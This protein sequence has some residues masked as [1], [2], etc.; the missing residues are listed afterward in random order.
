MCGIPRIYPNAVTVPATESF[1]GSFVKLNVAQFPGEDVE[2][3]HDHWRPVAIFQA[4]PHIVHSS[5]FLEIE[6]SNRSFSGGLQPEL[7][8]KLGIETCGI[9]RHDESPASQSC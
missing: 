9:N 8:N 7:S 2:K 1:D 5:L 4:A 3:R 6:P